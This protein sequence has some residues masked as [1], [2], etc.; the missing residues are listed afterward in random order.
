MPV[1]TD[2]F[3]PI[4]GAPGRGRNR[5][6]L[7]VA[8]AY[9][10]LACLYIILSDL[11]LFGNRPDL[12]SSHVISILKGLGFV[13]VTSGLLYFLI[14]SEE[15]ARNRLE[16]NHLQEEAELEQ[17]NLA[18]SESEENYRELFNQAIDCIL[19]LD[20]NGAVIDANSA[21]QQLL[22]Y[23]YDEIIH[24][25]LKALSDLCDLEEVYKQLS[26]GKTF[27]K[28]C[29][30]QIK[31]GNQ[32]PVEASIKMLLDGRI[33][34]VARDSRQ[35]ERA[36]RELREQNET[37]EMLLDNL[38]VIVEFFNPQGKIILA[39][40]SLERILGY[41]IDEALHSDILSMQQTDPVRLARV[42]EFIQTADGVWEKFPTRRKDGLVREML[43]ENIRLPDQRVVGIGID[44]T[45]TIRMQDTLRQTMETVRSLTVRL[46]EIEETERKR[47]SRELHDQVGQELTVLNI[48]LGL[49]RAM[50][51]KNSL[52]TAKG[53]LEESIQLVQL[54][55]D[56][57]RSV[58][59]ALTPPMLEEYGLLATLNWFASQFGEST[60][61]QTEVSGSELNLPDQVAITLFRITQEA[62]NNIAKH[63]AADR[64]T[65]DL[66]ETGKK[67]VLEIADNGDGFDPEAL[68]SPKTNSGWGLHIMNER[69]IS[70]G[71]SLHI[72][73][74]PGI[75][76]RI[77]VEVH[78]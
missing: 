74:Q 38:P 17:L 52:E 67:V 18:L 75:G 62:L 60:R 78:R 26:A 7:K 24:K 21:A 58:M 16:Q 64:A 29:R 66:R 33:Q 35:H 28:T 54:I 5:F 50:I 41:T 45:E 68:A 11:T 43:W 69:A 77:I 56:H 12:E 57:I 13:L 70:I 30:L 46:A 72:E 65:I 76:T 9:L 23:P 48:D 47:L 19:I 32:I 51:G 10:I 1:P 34:V 40:Q 4:L 27:L 15:I 42:K 49:I 37:L 39:N 73:S 44:V 25:D 3:Y 71:G 2:K 59:S 31:G 6:P 36:E 63:S 53:R 20:R 8:G 22:D 14:R 55:T 61:I